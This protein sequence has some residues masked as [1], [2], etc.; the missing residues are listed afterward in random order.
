MDKVAPFKF[1]T[2]HRQKT[3]FAPELYPGCT[4]LKPICTIEE[5]KD[6]A[7]ITKPYYMSVEL[8]VVISDEGAA[9]FVAKK[10]YGDLGKEL[11]MLKE[12]ISSNKSA[13]GGAGHDLRNVL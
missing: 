7:E 8:D 6:G 2:P 3:T 9:V 12:L 4:G 10:S 11:A 5:Y 1:G 13:L